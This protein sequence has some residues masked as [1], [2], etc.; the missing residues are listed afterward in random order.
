MSHPAVTISCD[1]WRHRILYYCDLVTLIRISMTNR[2]LRSVVNQ[3]QFVVNWQDKCWYMYR[4]CKCDRNLAYLDISRYCDFLWENV[5]S[6]DDTNNSMMMV[7]YIMRRYGRSMA[8]LL[9]QI[10]QRQPIRHSVPLH[11]GDRPDWAM[12]I[13]SVY[14]DDLI[15]PLPRM[16]PVPVEYAAT[17]MMGLNYH[18]GAYP[19]IWGSH[20]TVEQLPHNQAGDNESEEAFKYRQY[21]RN[22]HPVPYYI[23]NGVTDQE[24]EP[25]SSWPE[26]IEED[27]LH[28]FLNSREAQGRDPYDPNDDDDCEGHHVAQWV[29]H[30]LYETGVGNQQFPMDLCLHR[31]EI[32]P[33]QAFYRGVDYLDRMYVGLHQWNHVSQLYDHRGVVYTHHV[34]YNNEAGDFVPWA[35]NTLALLHSTYLRV[36]LETVHRFVGQLYP[37]VLGI[38]RDIQESVSVPEMLSKFRNL[39]HVVIE[40]PIPADDWLEGITDIHRKMFLQQARHQTFIQVVRH[41]L[42]MSE[43][44]SALHDLPG[45]SMDYLIPL[46]PDV[47]MTSVDG[48]L[49]HQTN[50][51]LVVDVYRLMDIMS[52]VVDF[53]ELFGPRE[54][55]TTLSFRRISRRTYLRWGLSLLMFNPLW[56]MDYDIKPSRANL[57][58]PIRVPRVDIT[59]NHRYQEYMNFLNRRVLYYKPDWTAGYLPQHGKTDLNHNRTGPQ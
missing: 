27:R 15:L 14:L 10:H 52:F 9:Q 29:R 11:P 49:G 6:M 51:Q 40:G 12:G 5:A 18:Q 35:L 56:K 38:A 54:H 33:K 30:K 31:D 50:P 34:R 47:L 42:E 2:L 39:D 7:D 36:W 26:V 16:L 20:L 3:P 17:G 13:S 37:F 19:Q 44:Q 48:S 28:A 43:L 46:I 24:Y 21:W 8:M 55:P 22:F 53:A 41:R 1:L 59:H 25:P 23:P 45:L 57:L 4:D 58:G 32:C